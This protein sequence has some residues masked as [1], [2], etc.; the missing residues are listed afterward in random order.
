MKKCLPALCMIVIASALA[1]F[2]QAQADVSFV[3]SPKVAATTPAPVATPV[4]A[5]AATTATPGAIPPEEP[6]TKKIKVGVNALPMEA[7]MSVYCSAMNASH[8]VDYHQCL[9][10]RALTS[11]KMCLGRTR[12]HFS[13]ILRGSCVSLYS[14]KTMLSGLLFLLAENERLPVPQFSTKKQI[15]SVDLAWRVCKG[16]PTLHPSSPPSLPSLP[17]ERPEQVKQQ[18]KQVMTTPKPWEA[19]ADDNDNDNAWGME[20]KEQAKEEEEDQQDEETEEEWKPS[21]DMAA[22]NAAQRLLPPFM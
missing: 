8:A 4:P 20:E 10:R 18:R 7:L 13:D 9:Q 2:S 12:H 3:S 14:L 22:S 11:N 16:L 5:T 21:H 19:T 1:F 17:G 15:V 6:A